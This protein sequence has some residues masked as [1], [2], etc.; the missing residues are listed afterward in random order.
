MSE[1]KGQGHSQAKCTFPSYGYRATCGRPAVNIYFTRHRISVHLVNDFSDS[2][3]NC[4]SCSEWVSLERFQ[5]SEVKGQGHSETKINALRRASFFLGDSL[6][7][8][9]DDSFKWFAPIGWNPPL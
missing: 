9:R 3:D 5:R 4:A 1:V 7:F 8:I 2:W 6:R